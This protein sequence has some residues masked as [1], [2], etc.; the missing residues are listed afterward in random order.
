MG[1]EESFVY[2]D[3]GR[4]ILYTDF[5]GDQRSYQYETMGTDILTTITYADQSQDFITQDVLGHRISV[6]DELGEARYDYD[7][8]NRLIEEVKPTGERLIYGYDDNGNQLTKTEAHQ[9]T[10]YSYSKRN[11]V[12]SVE[13]A[14]GV[15]SF[16]YDFD[17]HRI[18]K[19]A[20]GQTTRYLVDRNQSYAQVIAELT[21]NCEQDAGSIKT[22]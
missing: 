4:R 1:Q 12:V 21:E 7:D 22:K 10:F 17:G 2:D 3:A 20:Q 5:N 11:K 19:T 16:A 15:V 13:S 9:T 8:L 6:L 18:S 14:N